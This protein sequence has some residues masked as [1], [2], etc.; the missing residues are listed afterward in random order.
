MDRL[1]VRQRHHSKVSSEFSNIAPPP[2]APIPLN[3]QVLR[4]LQHRLDP[5]QPEVGSAAEYDLLEVPGRFHPVR[6]SERAYAPVTASPQA[7][8][9]YR[10]VPSYD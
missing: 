3:F 7:E 5:L 9:H 1:A 6:L 8:P 2:D 4:G 10:E